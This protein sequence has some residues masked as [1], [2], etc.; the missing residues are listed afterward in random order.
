MQQQRGSAGAGALGRGRPAP[1]TM[2]KTQ[3]DQEKKYPLPKA[4]IA[5]LQR[6]GKSGPY[7]GSNR[8]L[9]LNKLVGPWALL[10]NRQA[11]LDPDHR[12]SFLQALLPEPNEARAV[13]QFMQRRRQAQL[14]SYRKAGWTVCELQARPEWRFVSGLGMVNPLEANLVLHHIGGFPYIPGSSIKG[15]LRAYAELTLGVAPRPPQARARDFSETERDLLAVFGAQD[16]AGQVV[17]FDAFPDLDQV[18]LELDV[19]NVHYP[20][21]YQ[22]EQAP[23]DWQ[24]PVPVLFLAVGR[25]TRFAFAVASRDAGL[26]KRALGWLQGAL[27]TTG[28]GGKTSAGY[29]YFQ[30]LSGT[31]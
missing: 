8:S 14:A 22:R 6:Q 3:A 11:K 2:P 31:K 20:D 16:R 29:G 28:L 18:K 17:F 21:Y 5:V 19:I 26:A 24:N 23:T 1:G 12:R 13:R 7:A 4:T 27:Q 30:P 15:A 25:D 10:A 9:A